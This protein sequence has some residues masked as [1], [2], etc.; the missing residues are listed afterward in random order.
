MMNRAEVAGRAGA[1]EGAAAAAQ[2][3]AAAITTRPGRNSVTVSGI[4]DFNLDHIF[5]CGQC[6]RWAKQEDGSYTGIAMNRVVNM[7]MS[8]SDL[9]ISGSDEADFENIWR[10]YLDLDR[11]YGEIKKILGNSDPVMKLAIGA[12]EGIRIL[13]QDLWETIVSFIIS[14]N[15]NIPRIK[16][17]VEKLA[18]CFG[19]EIKLSESRAEGIPG[20]SGRRWYCVPD[21]ATLAVLT[22]EDLAPVRL[23]YR[24][25]YLVES[26]R[27]VCEKGLP[28]NLAELTEL[29]GVGPKVANCINLFGLGE[30]SSF[31]ID[32]WVK[33]VMHRLYGFEE[34]DVRGMASFAQESFG[35]LG[36]IAQQYLFYY[37]RGLE[38]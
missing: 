21:A 25:R 28:T 26:A 15:N 18:E 13:K 22:A 2:A 35:D 9:V 37:I 34:K 38:A 8:G 7:R 5:D 10:P 11:D 33:R 19:E 31:P 24:T 23:G 27:Q 29:T 36:G 12:G 14:Q 20:A 4:R 17:C 6:F 3:R 16:G 1:A 30:F 32:V